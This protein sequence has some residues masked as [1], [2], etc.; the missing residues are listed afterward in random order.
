MD[1]SS[2]TRTSS[3]TGSIYLLSIG[4]SR[5]PRSLSWSKPLWKGWVRHPL[6]RRGRIL[7]R[8]CSLDVGTSEET[9]SASV[10][11]GRVEDGRG[12]GRR[13]GHPGIRDV[14]LRYGVSHELPPQ[15]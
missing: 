13:Y 9:P 2:V 12:S 7:T 8:S 4:V 1:I 15:Q 10:T 11:S 6:N 14:W 3:T 5:N